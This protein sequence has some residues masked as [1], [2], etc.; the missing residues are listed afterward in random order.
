MQ[1]KFAISRALAIALVWT[2]V[3]TAQPTTLPHRLELGVDAAIVH[4]M[5][6]DHATTVEVPI[7]QIRLGYFVRSTILA[8]GAF[9]LSYA[10]IRGSSASR[11]DASGGVLLHVG[12]DT[13][14]VRPFLHPFGILSVASV[15]EDL[16]TG[17]VRRTNTRTGVGVGLGLRVPF[18]ERLATRFELQ[19]EQFQ[20]SSGLS[21]EDLLVFAVGLSVMAK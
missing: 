6:D 10:N 16:G 4:R 11:A 5:Q 8:E 3:L 14:R 7:Q 2:H 12:E 15:N 21:S 20:P 18:G 19:L 1:P 13:K 17:S 9:H